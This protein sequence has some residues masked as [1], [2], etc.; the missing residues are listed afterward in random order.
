MEPQRRGRGGGAAALLRDAG[1][2]LAGAKG[3]DEQ[4]A[5]LHQRLEALYSECYDVAETLRDL[6]SGFDFSPQELDELEGRAD[7]IYRLKKVRPHSGGHAGL[8]GKVPAG[9]GP[10]RLC[11]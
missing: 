6:E 3:L 10:D 2:A 11:R 5:Q 9:A 7:L 8:S 1:N 4:F